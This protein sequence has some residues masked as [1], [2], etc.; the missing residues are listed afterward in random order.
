V[1]DRRRSAAARDAGVSASSVP[2]FASPQAN[3]PGQGIIAS[4][5]ARFWALVVGLGV[6]TGLAASALMALLHLI[7]HL[8]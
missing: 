2:R 5:T 4:Y 6:I 7:E 1:S 8:S 3:V